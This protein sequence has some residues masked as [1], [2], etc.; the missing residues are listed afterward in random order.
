M[1]IHLNFI[2]DFPCLFF[3]NIIFMCINSLRLNWFLFYLYAQ[4][5]T[6]NSDG[7]TPMH[8]ICQSRAD[9][10]VQLMSTLSKVGH[11]IIS[12]SFFSR[13]C[14]FAIL[15]WDVSYHICNLIGATY[16]FYFKF[17]FFSSFMKCSI[18]FVIVVYLLCLILF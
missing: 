16:S 18:L 9:D 6:Q 10:S 4:V 17:T 5:N 1:I 12:F 8:V 15:Q 11:A 3:H 2:Y 14:L 7:N 13:V